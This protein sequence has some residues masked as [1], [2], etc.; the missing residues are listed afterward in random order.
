MKKT[1]TIL[2]N[3]HDDYKAFDDGLKEIMGEADFNKAT[4]PI[5]ELRAPDENQEEVREMSALL[6]TVNKKLDVMDG[7]LEFLLK[8]LE[9]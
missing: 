4:N 2:R 8:Y 7:K 3:K 1:K 9:L 5:K 6:A